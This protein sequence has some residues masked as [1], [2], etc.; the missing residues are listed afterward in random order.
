[1]K[2]TIKK[3]LINNIIGLAAIGLIGYFIVSKI[4]LA[5]R[6]YSEFQEIF[7]FVLFFEFMEFIIIFL[8]LI[9][10]CIIFWKN[11]INTRMYEH[12]KKLSFKNKIF[13]AWFTI[14]FAIP[15]KIVINNKLSNFTTSFIIFLI[16]VISFTFPIFILFYVIF[17]INVMESYFFAV[18]Y[19]ERES[20]KKFLDNKLFENNPTFS[21]D[22]FSFF[23]GN[24]DS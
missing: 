16:I 12:F 24:M 10:F 6:Y 7:L 15:N 22:Y 20:F 1:M 11:S 3:K 14:F 9:L 4:E 17:W 23:W 21:K 19:K 5:V 13:F 18:L 8:S 2:T